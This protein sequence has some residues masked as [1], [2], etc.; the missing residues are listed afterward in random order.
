MKITK[1][2]LKRIIREEKARLL[3]ENMGMSQNDAFGTGYELGKLERDQFDYTG[4]LMDLTPEEAMGLGHQAGLMDLDD[5]DKS[6]FKHGHGGNASMA[7]GQLQHIAQDAGEL[8]D[9]LQDNDELPE[10]F[11][12]KISAIA[13]QMQDMHDYIER[14]SGEIDY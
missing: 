7:R 13:D 4:D 5:D 12:S 10:W 14:K 3:S 8:A 11:K 2:Q 9:W 6:R 1:R